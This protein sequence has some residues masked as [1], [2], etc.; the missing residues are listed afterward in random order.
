MKN[1]K[2]SF[3]QLIYIR[4]WSPWWREFDRDLRNVDLFRRSNRLGK[5]SYAFIERFKGG[6]V[7]REIRVFRFARG[8]AEL[9]RMVI[10]STLTRAIA[11]CSQ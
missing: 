3:I 9:T 5:F 11:L 4:K 7:D 10:I 2:Y 8:S 1:E 6:G